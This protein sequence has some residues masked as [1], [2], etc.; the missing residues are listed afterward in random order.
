[1]R[2]CCRSGFCL[3]HFAKRHPVVLDML[4][5]FQRGCRDFPDHRV[6]YCERLRADRNRLRTLFCMG[7][8]QENRRIRLYLATAFVLP[9]R[10]LDLAAPGD[11]ASRPFGQSACFY[12][13]TWLICTRERRECEEP[14]SS[15]I[16]C[17]RD[18]VEWAFADS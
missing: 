2:R 6:A 18:R 16:V 1:M 10:A 8:D 3:R 9:D 14:S 12:R 4:M 7:I 11:G 15:E 13:S 17:A 5:G